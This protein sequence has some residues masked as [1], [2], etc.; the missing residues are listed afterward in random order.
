VIAVPTIEALALA[1]RCEQASALADEL[2]AELEAERIRGLHRGAL[3]EARA[4]VAVMA[5]DRAGFAHYAD[6]C[7]TEYRLGRNPALVA[8]YERLMQFAER[9]GALPTAELVDQDEHVSAVTTLVAAEPAPK[10]VAR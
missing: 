3:Y 5:G 2:I 8:K 6:R 10:R 1:G 4:K 7:S 9:H